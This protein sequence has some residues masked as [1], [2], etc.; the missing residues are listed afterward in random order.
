ME[1]SFKGKGQ[2]GM[3]YFPFLVLCQDRVPRPRTRHG[4]GGHN[5]RERV[6]GRLLA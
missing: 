3:G 1:E 6:A 2:E 5:G 4:L